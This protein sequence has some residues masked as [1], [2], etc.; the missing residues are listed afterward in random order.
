MKRTRETKGGGAVVAFPAAPARAVPEGLRLVGAEPS[1]DTVYALQ[2]LLQAAIAGEV[3]GVAV[4]AMFKRRSYTIDVTGE[5]RRSPTFTRG[6]VA[7][8]D[9]ELRDLITRQASP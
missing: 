5:A 4:V 9:D 6:M 1:P 7:A 2:E 3:I 8:L